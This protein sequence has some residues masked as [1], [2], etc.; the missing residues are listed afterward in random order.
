VSSEETRRVNG[1]NYRAFVPSP[2]DA[3][4]RALESSSA[5]LTSS[6]HIYLPWPPATYVDAPGRMADYKMFIQRLSETTTNLNEN[7][8]THAWAACVRVRLGKTLTH[9]PQQG[10]NCWGFRWDKIPACRYGEPPPRGGRYERESLIAPRM[11][12]WWETHFRPSRLW[13]L[14]RREAVWRRKS[15]MPPF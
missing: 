4:S 1:V 7:T 9:V 11:G 5:A 6:R 10:V 14:F 2:S 15:M 13:L 12:G 3:P 8:R